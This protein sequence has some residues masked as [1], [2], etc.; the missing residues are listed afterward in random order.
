MPT[1]PIALDL[2]ENMLPETATGPSSAATAESAP[3]PESASAVP[4]VSLP[5]QMNGAHPT[6]VAPAFNFGP[7]R[8]PLVAPIP[9][10]LRPR[11]GD[12]EEEDEDYEEHGGSSLIDVS[13]IA[14]SDF[15]AALDSTVNPQRRHSDRKLSVADD[16]NSKL[17][18]IANSM[19]SI[20]ECLGEDPRREG[21]V[22]T[23]MRYAKAMAFFTQG[24]ETSLT[25]IVNNAIF[26]EDCNE[27]VVIKNIE[28]YSLCEHHLVPFM[29][30]VHIGYIPN[31]RVLGLSKFARI[32][33]MFS[34]RLQVQERMTK[35]VANAIHSVLRPLGVA[36][37]IEA[38]HMCMIMRGVQK[39]GSH[40]TTSSVIGA[41]QKDPRTRA[42]FFSHL[43]R[44]TL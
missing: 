20:I 25:E 29:G 32:V 16:S 12:V 18:R 5:P 38:Q 17:Q 30:R 15:K 42:E 13:A 31:G 10:F 33:E 26:Q 41:F 3:G 24:Y 2:P 37:V 4:S 36:V 1:S 23:P 44:A 9:S 11:G 43:N 40:T 22:K 27:M 35:Q 14:D 7:Y 8:S 19:S 28:I 39:P 34:R 21:L 6:P